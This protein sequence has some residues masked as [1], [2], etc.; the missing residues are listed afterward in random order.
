[1]KSGKGTSRLWHR[2]CADRFGPLVFTTTAT[3]GVVGGW[4]YGNRCGGDIDTKFQAASYNSREVLNNKFSGL[5]ANIQIQAVAAETFHLM[6]NGPG[7]H[8]SAALVSAS[9]MEAVHKSAC[10]RAVATQPLRPAVL[11]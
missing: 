11:R 10:R 8:I 9:G 2:G 4:Y 3:A 1:M 5:V 6:V 7:Y